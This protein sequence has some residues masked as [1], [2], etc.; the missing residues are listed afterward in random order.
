MAKHIALGIDG[1][2][3]GFSDRMQRA[4][5]LKFAVSW[6]VTTDPLK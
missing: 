1:R 4:F 3:I 6:S 2:D 5:A